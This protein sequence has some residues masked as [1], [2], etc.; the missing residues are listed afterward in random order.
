MLVLLCFAVIVLF[1]FCLLGDFPF[2]SF[3]GKSVF[4]LVGVFVCFLF[5]VFWGVVVLV[6]WLVSAVKHILFLRNEIANNRRKNC[7][8]TAFH[9]SFLPAVTRGS[10]RVQKNADH[11][12][13]AGR[14]DDGGCCHGA[15]DHTSLLK[16]VPV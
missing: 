12:D 8:Q 16:R 14:H 5:W 7:T 3:T 9:D 15:A 4:C 13:L 2:R 11:L 1:C 6:N 10:T